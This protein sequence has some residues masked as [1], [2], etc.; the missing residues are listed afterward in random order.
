MPHKRNPVLSENLTGL[1]RLVRK[2]VVPAMENVALWH[3]R[4]IS[5]SSVERNIGPDTTITLDFALARLTG[6]VENLLIYPDNMLANMN[7]FRGLVHSQRVLLALTQKGLSR[8]DS[9]RLVQ[10]NAMKVWEKGADFMEELKADPEVKAVLSDA[11]IEE[12]FDL[13]Y[14]TKHVDTIFKRVFG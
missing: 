12:K 4:D 2:A 1:A 3:E 6:L 13:A 10:R 11:E 8:E 14:H 5:H 7:K 9:Y